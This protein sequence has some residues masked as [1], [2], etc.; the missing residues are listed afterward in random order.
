M[1]MVKENGGIKDSIWRIIF[2]SGDL[3]GD[4]HHWLQPTTIERDSSEESTKFPPP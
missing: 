4:Q 3:S 2:R 1:D